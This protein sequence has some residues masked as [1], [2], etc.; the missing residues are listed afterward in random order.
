MRALLLSPEWGK[1]GNGV[2]GRSALRHRQHL[3]CRLCLHLRDA[4]CRL[5]PPRD[6]ASVSPR[7]T[8]SPQQ[9]RPGSGA[10]RE[11]REIPTKRK[12]LTEPARELGYEG[13]AW[14]ALVYRLT[15]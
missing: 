7:P 8:E 9:E 12:S 11:P 1:L 15:G 6:S 5:V 10:V 14:M 2:M 13:K 4:A 3:C